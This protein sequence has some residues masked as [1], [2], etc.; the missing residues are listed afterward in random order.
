[1][2]PD[3]SSDKSGK[4]KQNKTIG[5]FLSAERKKASTQ[6]LYPAKQFLVIKGKIKTFQMNEKEEFVVRSGGR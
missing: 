2:S 3:F 1:M 4:T 5:T 6:N